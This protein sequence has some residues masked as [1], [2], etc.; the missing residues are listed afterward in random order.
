MALR[1]QFICTKW[2]T[3]QRNT[4]YKPTSYILTVPEPLVY[5][6]SHICASLIGFCK[7]AH[8]N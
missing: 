5:G 8:V 6:K 3:G 4:V 7:L 1:L 2:H